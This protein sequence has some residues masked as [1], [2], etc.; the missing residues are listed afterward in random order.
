[1]MKENEPGAAFLYQQ[2]GEWIVCQICPHACRLGPGQAGRCRVNANRGGRRELLVYG[3][4]IAAGLDPVE[5]KPLRHFHP[6]SLVYTIGLPGCT[7][8]CAFCRN[9]ELSQIAPLAACQP[10]SPAAQ[11][12]TAEGVVR[13]ALELG[14]AGLGFSY[15]E[16]GAWLDFALAVMRRGR[17]AGLYTA[18]H[19]NGF[20][21]PR[22]VEA[23]APWL[24][25]VCVDLK[26]P[27]RALYARWT[28]GWLEAVLQ[29]ACQFQAAGVWVEV[30]TP[31]LAGINDSPAAL[32]RMARLV[33]SRLGASTPWHLG[34][35]VPAWKIASLPVTGG[36]ALEQAAELAH[37]AGLHNVYIQGAA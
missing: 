6:G 1:M 5:K 4:V 28:G 20:L 12:W 24:D 8:G 36:A 3:R 19:T 23:A 37:R 18:W 10:G 33:A 16:P 29:A 15:S 17:A 31:L 30:S 25:A 11:P 35:G 7:L 14:A 9:F 34:R 13:A 27:S 26:F 2:Q 32:H 21:T 22:A